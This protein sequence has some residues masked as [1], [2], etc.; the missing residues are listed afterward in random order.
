MIKRMYIIIT[1]ISRRAKFINSQLIFLLF[2]SRIFGMNIIAGPA[3]AMNGFLVVTT[4]ENIKK[5]YH[6]FVPVNRYPPLVM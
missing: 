4:K 6:Y 5:I 1:T 2:I 3:I